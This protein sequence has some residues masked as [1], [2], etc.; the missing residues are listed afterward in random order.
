MDDLVYLSL[1]S[2]RGD[3]CTLIRR[4]LEIIS[5]LPGVERCTASSLYRTT[6]VNCTS[7]TPF[8]NAACSL[9]TTL[10]PEAL[11]DSLHRIEIL[12]GKTAKEKSAPRL[13]DIDI[14]LFGNRLHHTQELCIPHP[15]WSERLF[16][17]IPLSELTQTLTLPLNT[18]GD[19]QEINL[20]Q[21]LQSF[22]NPHEE[23]VERVF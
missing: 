5:H 1:G 8:I 16:V 21:Y 15:R 6:P 11:Y 17:L 4:A 12:L 14:V 9:Y 19:T 2:N 7:N 22:A 18:Q 20:S 3:S 23:R 10:T 13:I